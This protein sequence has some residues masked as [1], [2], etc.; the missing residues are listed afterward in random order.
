MQAIE[1]ISK[2]LALCKD[3]ERELEGE[4]GDKYKTLDEVVAEF[5]AL[6]LKISLPIKMSP[7]N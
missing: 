6:A 1:Q 2:A 3:L 7:N 4:S 5:K